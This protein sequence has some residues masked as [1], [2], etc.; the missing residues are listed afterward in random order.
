M[1]TG[2]TNERTQ[3]HTTNS[4][5]V[6]V[7]G[8][9]EQQEDG[10]MKGTTPISIDMRL[11]LITQVLQPCRCS[12]KRSSLLTVWLCSMNCVMQG[13]SLSV[14]TLQSCSVFIQRQFW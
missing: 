2:L 8:C 14:S 13:C 6:L 3:Q 4:Y 11:C 10:H 12:A 9:I 7:P 1:L 5:I